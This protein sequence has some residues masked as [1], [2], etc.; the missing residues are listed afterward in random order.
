MSQE[1]SRGGGGRVADANGPGVE[2][3]RV[4]DRWWVGGQGVA[5]DGT[6]LL[7]AP[8]LGREGFERGRLRAQSYFTQ[9]IRN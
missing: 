7:R 5:V 9:L 6:A 4:A 8:G 2:V 1:G 3:C